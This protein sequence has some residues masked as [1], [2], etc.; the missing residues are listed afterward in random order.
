MTRR[1]RRTRACAALGAALIVGAAALGE[2][3]EV[4]VERELRSGSR[5][6][7]GIG[8]ERSASV[9]LGDVDGD[10]DLDAVVA[11]GRHW[12]AQNLVHLNQGRGR[13]NVIRPLGVDWATSYATELVDLDG[14]GDL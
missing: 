7:L 13:F 2:R 10:G 12:P 4:P 3:R 14:D 8:T 5:N 1:A 9:R 6:L 11:N